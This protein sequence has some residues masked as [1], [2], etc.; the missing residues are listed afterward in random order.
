V[1]GR[2]G[3]RF[4]EVTNR[5]CP[6]E[7][8]ARSL[9]LGRARRALSAN[10]CQSRRASTARCEL[11]AHVELANGS[12][13]TAA[14][15]VDAR[16]DLHLAFGVATVPAVAAYSRSM[17]R[18]CQ[19]HGPRGALQRPVGRLRQRAGTRVAG[20]LR[21]GAVAAAASRTWRIFAMATAL[22]GYHGGRCRV[23]H[24]G[25]AG[26]G[27][28]WGSRAALWGLTRSSWHSIDRR[29]AGE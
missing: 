8:R 26:E 27:V 4:D 11:R 13:G 23:P 29:G 28:A 2:S 18:W 16:P 24:G 6:R 1:R 15:V 14:V 12:R 17:C 5:A 3:Q 10:R 25:Q 19:F 21:G 20:H 7:G 22:E 9:S